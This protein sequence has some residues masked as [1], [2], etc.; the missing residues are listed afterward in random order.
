MTERRGHGTEIAMNLD[1]KEYNGVII[2]SGDGLFY[3]VR[4]NISDGWISY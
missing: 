3:E 1:L 2:V 4:N